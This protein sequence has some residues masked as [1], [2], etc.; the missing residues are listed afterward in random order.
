VIYPCEQKS[1]EAQYG[2]YEILLGRFRRRLRERRPNNK[3][4]VIGYSFNDEHIN[5][6]IEDSLRAIGSTLTVYAFLGP[7]A[8]THSQ[9]DRIKRIADRCES[10]FNAAI[11]SE[12]F[13]GA[14]LTDEE[15]DKVKDRDLW[16]FE[17]LVD[18]VVG[19][20]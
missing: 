10:R 6:A 1:A 19:G 20:K 8:D 17:N 9:A 3:L 5:V 18:L 12:T 4:I 2:V 16:R 15:W 7:G 14:A 13:V 11:G